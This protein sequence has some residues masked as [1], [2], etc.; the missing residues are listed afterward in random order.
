[1]EN[2]N[3]LI[4]WF[5]EFFKRFAMKSPAFFQVL[6]AVGAI[7]AILAGIPVLLAKYNLGLPHKWELIA[8]QTA[9]I[10]VA[11]GGAVMWIIAKLPVDQKVHAALPEETKQKK[12][13][14]T[15]QNSIPDPSSPTKEEQD[16]LPDPVPLTTL[17][18]KPVKKATPKKAAKKS[19]T[20]KSK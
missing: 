11:V 5:I 3:Q 13:P 7:C 17:K 19:V 1:M 4:A 14:Y 9:A 16:A 2:R 10:A 12:L 20:K 15:Q 18:K 6:Q 8:N